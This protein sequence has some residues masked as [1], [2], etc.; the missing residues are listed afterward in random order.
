MEKHRYKYEGPVMEF[1]TCISN[2]WIGETMAVS[3]KKARCNLAYQ[4]KNNY[5]RCATAKITLPGKIT[6]VS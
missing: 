6:L 2:R 1:N 3:E 5:N 4:F